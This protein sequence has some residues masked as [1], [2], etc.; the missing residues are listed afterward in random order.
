VTA[1]LIE[2]G[3]DA[4]IETGAS[5]A[6]VPVTDTIKI[7]DDTLTVQGTPPRHNL[8][9][10]QTPQVFRYGLILEAYRNIKSDVTDDARAIE[11]N[12]GSVKIYTGSYDNIKITMPDDLALAE[13][14]MKKRKNE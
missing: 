10:V 9:S 11:L 4:A 13:I 5:V 1:E 6:A 14:L 3:L 12:G 7:A 8:W 2:A